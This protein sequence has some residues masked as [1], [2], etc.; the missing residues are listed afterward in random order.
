MR[1]PELILFARAPVP[2]E[3]KTRL[4]PV[5]TA[6]QAADV[7][8]VLIRATV[9]LATGHWP[10]PVSL[11][12]SPDVSHPLFQELMREYG[13]RLAPQADG[14]LGR[15]MAAALGEGIARNGAAAVM[16]CDVPHCGWETLNEANERV[17][18]GRYVLGPAMD[19]GYYFIG[20]PRVHA[21]L[22]EGIE[23]GGA[24]VLETTL[25]RAGRFGIEF[26]LLPERRDI[27][28][29]DDLRAVARVFAPLRRFL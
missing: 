25:A 10:G 17:A 18:R 7:A 23:W 26:D 14:D 15:R 24:K 27:D 5:Y 13:L 4:L 8:A 19:G 22:F 29:A 28:S 2:G 20:M 9:E 12:A 21:G 1:Q 6:T 11:Y 3:A 16:G